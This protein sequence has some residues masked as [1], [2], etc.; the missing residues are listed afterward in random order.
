[1]RLAAM[2]LSLALGACQALP[3]SCPVGAMGKA[4]A[5]LSSRYDSELA[6]CIEDNMDQHAALECMVEVDGRYAE[7]WR[8]Y[9]DTRGE[10]LRCMGG[11]K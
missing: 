10:M 8:L 11:A 4:H 2:I 3:P 6:S 5:E 1:M 9:D 7:A